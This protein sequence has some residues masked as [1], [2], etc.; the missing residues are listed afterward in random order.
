M[1][2]QLEKWNPGDPNSLKGYPA[3]LPPPPSPEC[4]KNMQAH[5]IKQLRKRL[6]QLRV[7]EQ[8]L[9]GPVDSIAIEY[10]LQRLAERAGAR[11]AYRTTHGLAS[12]FDDFGP[13]QRKALY[14][15]LNS[16]EENIP[17]PGIRWTW[18]SQD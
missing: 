1:I 6:E 8:V 15:V 7:K 18:F 17:S 14:Q 10:Q 16:I 12:V 11:N 9:N 2:S 5:A 3:G 13:E 4:V